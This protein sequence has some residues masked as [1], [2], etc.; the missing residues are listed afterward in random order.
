MV[1]WQGLNLADMA[2]YSAKSQGRNL[3]LGIASAVAQ[4]SAALREIEADF[5]LAWQEGR[6]TLTRLPG[7]AAP[8]VPTLALAA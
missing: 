3:A 5:E 6:A 7:P 2:L 4:D 8:A 1:G